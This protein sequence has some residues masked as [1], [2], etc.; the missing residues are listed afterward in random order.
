MASALNMPIPQSAADEVFDNLSRDLRSRQ[1]SIAEITEMIH[2]IHLNLLLFKI[3]YAVNMLYL[4]LLIT[5]ILF[6][7]TGGKSSP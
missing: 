1:Q 3:F 6:C 5:Y 7:M 4:A 2:V